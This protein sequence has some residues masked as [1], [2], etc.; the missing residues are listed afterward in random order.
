MIAALLLA[1]GASRRF[2]AAK[3]LQDLDGKAIVRWAAESV[4]QSPVDEVIVVVAPGDAAAVQ[5]ALHGLVVRFESNARAAEGMASS[6]ATGVAAVSPNAEAVVVALGD[7]P[8]VDP[9][10]ARRVIEEHRTRSAAIVAPTF[11]GVRGHPV[12]FGRAVFPE[13]MALTGD[14]GA[15]AVADRD[16]SRLAIVDFDMPKPVDVDTPDDL[17]RLRSGAQFPSRT[18]L[19][20]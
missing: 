9:A 4:L 8:R 15:R 11:R 18:S 17:A 13:L 16:P 19:L 1:A 6:I 7:E 20:P 14:R 5:T 12:L 3:L 2:G 10:V